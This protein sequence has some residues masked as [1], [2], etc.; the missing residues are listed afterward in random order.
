LRRASRAGPRG[1]RSS[2]APGHVRE[3]TGTDQGVPATEG[4]SACAASVLRHGTLCA[5]PERGPDIL[6][7]TARNAVAGPFGPTLLFALLVALADLLPA[8]RVGTY[9]MISAAG[10]EDRALSLHTHTGLGLGGRST[11]IASSLHHDVAALLRRACGRSRGPTTG[12]GSS[13]SCMLITG[14]PFCSCRSL[15]GRP[16]S[17]CR[18]PHVSAAR[19][20]R[21]AGG[22]RAGFATSLAVSA[23]GWWPSCGAG[24][25][26][27]RTHWNGVGRR[28]CRRGSNYSR[29]TPTATRDFSRRPRRGPELAR[30]GRDRTKVRK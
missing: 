25:S 23:P 19:L 2:L 15:A 7:K 1:G 28:R 20:V 18:G 3:G 8:P 10:S 21:F 9:I 26:S 13:E 29:P 11:R 22:D 14:R 4:P 16:I 17:G 6:W 12:S 27:A 5:E 24:A 30:P